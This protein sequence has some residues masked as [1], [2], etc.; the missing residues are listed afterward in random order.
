M[1]WSIANL[2]HEVS[3]STCPA[4]R[5][6]RNFVCLKMKDPRNPD[7]F[8]H[9]GVAQREKAFVIGSLKPAE[10]AGQ[11]AVDSSEPPAWARRVVGGYN[12][13]AK[14]LHQ[15]RFLEREC[16]EQPGG[17][18]GYGGQQELAPVHREEFVHLASLSNDLYHIQTVS[19]FLVLLV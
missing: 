4:S 7:L 15:A 13:V 16:F 19:T 18:Q 1:V 6:S 12:L 2:Q 9:G 8:E 17:I 10:R 14:S 5:S 11:L 3:F